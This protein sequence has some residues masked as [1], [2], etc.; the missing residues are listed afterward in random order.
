MQNTV[1]R[2]ATECTGYTNTQHLHDDTQT[3]PLTEHF[4]LHSSQIKQ[5]AQHP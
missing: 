4:K 5:T 2:T 1:L 3:L